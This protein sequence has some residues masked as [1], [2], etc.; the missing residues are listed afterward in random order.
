MIDPATALG[1]A[2]SNWK[3]VAGV[4]LGA[5][6]AFNVGSCM[7]HNKGVKAERSR[8]Q[9]EAAKLKAKAAEASQKASDQ[10]AQDTLTVTTKAEERTDAIRAGADE[11]PSGPEL[12]LA[13]SRLRQQ[14]TPDARLPAVCRPGSPR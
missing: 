3:A 10:R 8:W 11:A 5:L 12:R 1:L 14:G 4:L 9:A 6:L 2:R 13:C 7:G